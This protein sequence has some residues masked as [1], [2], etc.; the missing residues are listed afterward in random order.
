MSEEIIEKIKIFLK[1]ENNVIA[2]FKE[3]IQSG[4]IKNIRDKNINFVMEMIF[5]I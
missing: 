1:D 4:N 3:N 2:F 5:L